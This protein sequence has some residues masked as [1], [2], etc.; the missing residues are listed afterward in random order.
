MSVLYATYISAFIKTH[1]TQKWNSEHATSFVT[2]WRRL[3]NKAENL[4][5]KSNSAAQPRENK[6]GASSD[7]TAA[8]LNEGYRFVFVL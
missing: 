5:D 6:A 7:R 1:T 2:F 8:E 4:S 3:F